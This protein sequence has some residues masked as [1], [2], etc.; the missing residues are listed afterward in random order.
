MED[1]ASESKKF[2][3]SETIA[4]PPEQIFALLADP[5]WHTALDGAGMIQG[6]DSGPSPVTGVGDAFVMNMDQE[7]I[8]Q[9]QMRSEVVAYEPGSRIS[10]APAIYPPGALSHLI[11]ELDPSGHTW[12]WDLEA[13][14][15][16]GTKVTHTYDWSGVK[17]EGAVALYPR[18]TEEQMRG[19]ISRISDAL[20]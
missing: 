13:T 3:L 9:Y 10:W 12:D 2:R 5:A 4:A 1:P 11:G 20:S 7:G 19:S 17:D 6:L 14:A 8:G 16:G 18:V 15:D